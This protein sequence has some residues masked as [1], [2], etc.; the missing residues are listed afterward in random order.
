MIVDAIKRANRNEMRICL[1]A[2]ERESKKEI[3]RQKGINE[4]INL[5]THLG[6]FNENAQSVSHTCTLIFFCGYMK[7]IIH[8]DNI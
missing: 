6:D 1:Q 3:T 4:A 7:I 5:I 8:R 2:Q